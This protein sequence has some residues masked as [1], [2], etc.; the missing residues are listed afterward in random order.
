MGQLA[1]DSDVQDLD[2]TILEALREFQALTYDHVASV[3]CGGDKRKAYEALRRLFDNGCVTTYRLPSNQRV[4]Y[5]VLTPNGVAALGPVVGTWAPPRKDRVER[6]IAVNDLYFKL[7]DAGIPAESVARRWDALQDLNLLPHYSRL[8]ARVTGADRTWLLYLREE[9]IRKLLM[10][11]MEAVPL[12]FGHVLLYEESPVRDIR[13]FVKTSVPQN[14]HCLQMDALRTAFKSLALEPDALRRK[15]EEHLSVLQ[16]GRTVR[17]DV[18]PFTYSWERAADG[19]RMILADMSTNNLGTLRAVMGLDIIHA[20]KP[21]QNWG[22][23]VLIFANNE[24]DAKL[25]R[26]LI[27]HKEW[28]WLVRYDLPP[29][30]SLFRSQERDWAPWGVR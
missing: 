16:A 11:S 14:L 28:L 17:L 12:Q 3:A 24:R 6:L 25:W 20:S 27:G 18:C 10:K 19:S 7:L 4:G 15:M 9:G 30:K 29:G 8:A 13:E 5:A 2:R 1:P 21:E 26:S 22:H 23:N